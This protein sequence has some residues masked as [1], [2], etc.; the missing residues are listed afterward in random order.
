MNSG[1][2]G[3]Q[4]LTACALVGITAGTVAGIHKK[5]VTMFTTREDINEILKEVPQVRPTTRGLMFHL[6]WDLPLSIPEADD[7]GIASDD[8]YRALH[9]VMEAL[10]EKDGLVGCALELDQAMGNGAQLTH[11]VEMYAP[12]YAVT[13]STVWDLLNSR[14]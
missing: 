2:I 11:L 10:V 4:P 5:E 6:L 3:P 14:T 1:P 13:F 7:F 12:E 8:H 9:T